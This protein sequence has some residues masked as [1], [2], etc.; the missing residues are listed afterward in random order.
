MVEIAFHHWK[1][2]HRFC[3]ECLSNIFLNSPEK[4]VMWFSQSSESGVDLAFYWT[5]WRLRE[6]CWFKD[7]LELYGNVAF[8]WKRTV[9]NHLQDYFKNAFVQKCFFF[10]WLFTA[11][12]QTVTASGM[13]V[14]V[15]WIICAA[16]LSEIKSD[17]MQVEMLTIPDT[18]LI[19]ISR[20]QKGQELL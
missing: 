11:E 9:Q 3:C 12:L 2:V 20:R 17:A 4:N 10:F 7:S 19:W 13:K 16:L 1:Q 14:T 6:S 5:D 18:P 8:R 15:E